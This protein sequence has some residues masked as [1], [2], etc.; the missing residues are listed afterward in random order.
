MI[1]LV[2]SVGQ[3]QKKSLMLILGSAHGIDTVGAYVYESKSLT[4]NEE[5]ITVGSAQFDLG[6]EG[7]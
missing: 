4:G 5:M 3:N 6:R 2:S 1:S 7:T